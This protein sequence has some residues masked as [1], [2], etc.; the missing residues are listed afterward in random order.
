MTLDIVRR[1][2]KLSVQLQKPAAES[3]LG[4]RLGDSPA[5]FARAPGTPAVMVCELTQ[6]G[7]VFA[8]RTLR[9]GDILL[10]IDGVAVRESEQGNK[11]LR[12]ASGDVTLVVERASELLTLDL[13]IPP[14][15]Q[16]RIGVMLDY[17]QPGGLVANVRR[18]SVK[19][20]VPPVSLWTPPAEE[21]AELIC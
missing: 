18:G 7:L 5:R 13:Y 8:S 6:T 10:A 2:D 11:A 16:S 12:S 14:G 17:G 1:G 21:P 20:E 4:V 9:V 15:K 3:D 19:I